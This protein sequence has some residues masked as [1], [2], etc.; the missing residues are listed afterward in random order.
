[1]QLSAFQDAMAD[2]LLHPPGDRASEH[3]A[4]LDALASQPGFSVYRNTVLKACLDALQASYPTVCQL[5]GEAW[6]R[7]AAAVYVPQAP[8]VD[9]QLV[10]YGDGF[11][12]FLAA[13]PPAA[14]LP[15]LA[16]VARLDRLWTESH[17]AADAPVLD[18]AW[19]AAQP[20]ARL[21]GCVLA[22]HPASRWIWSPEHPAFAL[23]HCHREGRALPDDLPWV[24]DGGLLTR[25]HGAVQWTA[26]PRGGVAMLDACAAGMPIED[27]TARALAADPALDLPGLMA[28]LLQAG[29][30]RLPP[31][32]DAHAPIPD[33]KP[34]TA[35]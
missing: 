19:L 33:P 11:A 34:E 17:L 26:L 28:V 3:P 5:V 12:D 35:P 7:A 24:A 1:M 4:W 32:G 21:A 30:W 9:G 15:Y 14:E 10:R 29:A 27:A 20:P 25:P 23:W 16:A 8:P 18:A 31:P 22:P 6:F 13:F 2:A